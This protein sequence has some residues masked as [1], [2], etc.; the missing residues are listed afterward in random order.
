MQV[1]NLFIGPQFQVNAESSFIRPGEVVQAVIKDRFGTNKATVIMKGQEFASKFEGKIPANDSVFVEVV[2]IDEKGQAIIKPISQDQTPSSNQNKLINDLMMKMGLDPTAHPEL[3][4]TLLH[5]S[6]KGY[7]LNKD[8]IATIKN[9]LARE[10]GSFDEKFSTIQAL[11]QRK[12]EITATQLSAIHNVLQ[13]K[14]AIGILQTYLQGLNFSLTQDVEQELAVSNNHVQTKNQLNKVN[15]ILSSD[16]QIEKDTSNSTS[17]ANPNEDMHSARIQQETNSEN[18]DIKEEFSQTQKIDGQMK[19][20]QAE[21]SIFDDAMKMLNLDSKNVIVTEITKKLSQMA[22]DFNKMKNDAVKYLDHISRVIEEN[23][24]ISTTQVKQHLESTINKLDNAI[25]KG[26]YMLYTDMSTE[27][28][29][30]SASSQL[31]KAKDL[32]AKGSYSEATEIVKEVKTVLNNITFAPK[33]TKVMHYVSEQSLLHKETQAPKQLLSDLQQAMKPIF[34]Q[35]PSARGVLETVKRM[36]LTHENQMAHALM[37][38]SKSE[39]EPNLKTTLLK[40]IQ[41]EDGNPRKIQALEQSLSNLTGQQ[42]LSKPN[43]QGTQNIFMQL[44]VLLDKEIENVKV[45]IN[46]QKKGKG[47]DWEN[48]SLY[49]VLGTK[50]LGDLGIL[51]NANNRNLSITLKNNHERFAEKAKYFNEDSIQRLK[52]IGYNVGAINFRPFDEQKQ[53]NT[54][55]LKAEKELSSTQITSEK[56]YDFKV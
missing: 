56:G 16:I 7:S 4:D 27:K 40:M 35:E 17:I 46:S 19:L 13:G 5:L 3:R 44:P 29:L 1:N 37:G 31:A 51:V 55:S 14:S 49:F 12:L 25:L 32:I 53:E 22:I 41:L 20:S 43:S 36:G 26:N 30:L 28:Q 39:N 52:E 8:D 38:S 45:Y 6:E 11:A 54:S 48:C 24:P 9:F 34:E 50:N 47:V 23:K 15:E 18:S 2:R 21:Q 10:Q 42:L 33:D